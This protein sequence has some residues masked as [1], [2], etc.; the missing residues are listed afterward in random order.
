MSFSYK[1]AFGVLL[2]SSSA[3]VNSFFGTGGADS[4]KG[5][6]K[7]DIMRGYGG[8]DS[9]YGGAGDDTYVVS[10][11]KDKVFEAKGEGVDTVRSSVY[12]ILGANVENLILEGNQAWYGGG[13]DL[14]NVIVGNEYAQQ[15]N[16]GAGNDVL[17]GGGG[18]D[19]FIVTAGN[20]SDVIMDFASGIDKIQ[21]GGYGVTAFK[22]IQSI[23]QQVGNDTVLHF[24]NGEDLIL[25]NV[26]ATRLAAT[27]FTYELDRSAFVQSFGDEF[28]S[29]S[30]YSK[31]GTWRTEF[32]NGG[33]GT[34]ASR[35]LRTEAQLY[36][37]EDWGG[38]GKKA[39]GVNPFSIDDGV[40]TITAERASSDILQYMDGHT[41]TSGL[42]TSK[43]T[44][45]QQYG[46]FEIRAQ[47]P[48]G[49]GFWP[50]FWLLPTDNSWP[51][52]LDIFEQHG[53]DPNVL[54]MTTHGTSTPG[55]TMEA[56]DRAVLDTTQFHTYGVDWN[57][58]RIIYYIDG[59]EVARQATPAAMKKE[60]YM[61]VNLAVGGTESWS[62]PSDASTPTGE[63]KIDYI[64]AYRTSD[65]VSTTSNGKHVVYTPTASSNAPQPV[66]T[67]PEPA[68]PVTTTPPVTT[69]TPAPTT[70]APVQSS[71]GTITGKVY[72][73]TS[74][75]D[76]F[77]VS[78][79]LDKVVEALNGGTDT[80]FASDSYVLGDNVENLTLSG[81]KA[82]DGTGNALDNRLVGN[83][84]VNLLK[85]MAGNDYLDGAGGADTLMG[86]IGDDI[87]RVDDKA[88]KIVEYANEGSDL[89]V[90]SVSYTL[91]ANVE[92]LRLDGTAS[93][94]GI[95][96][97]EA[98]RLIGNGGNNV[99]NGLGGN[100][101]ID[102]GA[103]NDTLIGGKGDDVYVVDST[104]DRVLENA[105]E[106]NDTVMSAVSFTL[107]ANVETLRL[108]GAAA[109][110]GAGN[111]LSNKLYGN[112][113]ANKLF[114]WAGD[115]LLDGG[116]GNDVLNG[117]AGTD[118]LTGGA[119]AD[120]FVFSTG[121]GKDN[122]TDFQHGVDKLVLV[123]VKSSAVSI[124]HTATATVVSIGA[125]KITL[126]GDT[127]FGLSDITYMTTG[128]YNSTLGLMA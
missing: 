50:A 46:Y 116:A 6:A 99:L 65:T 110:N 92:N 117:G 20:G 31:G 69:P 48:S 124:S 4:L 45:A 97:A 107:P 29:L 3:A 123:N 118:T 120:T 101:Y 16:G 60:M 24:G 27:D 113:A 74:G 62:G 79:R 78:S 28:N 104:G 22:Q 44:F 96:N 54:Y 114:G 111:A 13:N 83:S 70:T 43:F 1:N 9:Y 10:S 64:R 102:G 80:V 86:G 63:M 82:L 32:G 11:I 75:N 71:N 2:N 19:R 67:T 100:D 47:M 73:G 14:D 125:D 52:E 85:G 128:E 58:E 81:D 87:Y 121:Y 94:N 12:H 55:K 105:D 76:V 72:N 57:G 98:N 53:K 30:L 77:R 41:W 21:L 84:A 23:A 35:T 95:G 88:V 68:T 15:I 126:T 119:G 25:R 91:S 36:F 109:I 49:N 93:I 90:S 17:I 39:L 51:P 61:L 5:T 122:V 34:I 127:Q 66:S 18:A 108:T 37:D 56:Q 33:P 59:M 8:G 38:T 112:A 106:G 40:L 89:V 26:Q 103:G 7:A 42:L 115:D